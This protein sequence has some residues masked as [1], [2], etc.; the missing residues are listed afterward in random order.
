MLR[1][2]QMRYRKMF[3]KQIAVILAPMVLPVL[4]HAK[5]I[6]W[7]HWKSIYDSVETEGKAAHCELFI[8]DLELTN[9]E[10]SH[11]F[12]GQKLSKESLVVKIKRRRDSRDIVRVG[13]YAEVY[14]TSYD[15][16]GEVNKSFEGRKKLALLNPGYWGGRGDPSRLNVYLDTSWNKHGLEFG[17]RYVEK[18][19]IFVDLREENGLVSRLWLKELGSELSQTDFDKDTY[20]FTDPVTHEYEHGSLTSQYLWQTSGSRVFTERSECL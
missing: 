11:L 16:S 3:R 8:E 15:H 7:T 18:L 19:N 13:A 4:S 6:E 10:G 17:D 9:W 5:E 20:L 12:Q 1:T 14:E 2:I